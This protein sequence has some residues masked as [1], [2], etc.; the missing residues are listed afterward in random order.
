MNKKHHAQS[1]S[2]FVPKDYHDAK[3]QGRARQ[4]KSELCQP[5]P[6]LGFY[7]KNKAFASEVK[8]LDLVSFTKSVVQKPGLNKRASAKSSE[9]SKKL[10]WKNSHNRARGVKCAQRDGL[11]VFWLGSNSFQK[12]R[13][14]RLFLYSHLRTDRLVPLQSPNQNC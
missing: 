12:R 11:H 1:I 3:F 14:R 4:I 5:L 8:I 9:Y 7:E 2:Y 13:K 10:G 6:V